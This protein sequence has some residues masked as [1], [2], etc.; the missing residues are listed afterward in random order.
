MINNVIFDIEE[1][2]DTNDTSTDITPFITDINNSNIV[3]YQSNQTD[4]IPD[5]SVNTI[6]NA[7]TSRSPTT[8]TCTTFQ[9]TITVNS[10]RYCKANIIII[11]YQIN[12]LH[13]TGN[14]ALIDRGANGGVLGSD[15]RI[16]EYT[17]RSITLTD[18]DNHQLPNLCICTAAAYTLTS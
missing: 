14:S 5:I 2:I 11:M 18:I 9:D 7:R 6:T 12:A 10:I 16:L 1:P 4:E 17:N 13:N 8:N 15:N 3:S